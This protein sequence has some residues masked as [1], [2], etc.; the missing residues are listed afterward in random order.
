MTAISISSKP[1]AKIQL[2]AGREAYQ[3]IMERGLRPQ[4]VSLMIGASGGPKWLI[5]SRLDQ[6]L[7]EHFFSQAEQSIELVGSSIGAWR[8]ACYARSN[9]LEAIREFERLY[10]NQRYQRPFVQQDITDFIQ[11]VVDTLFGGDR[12]HEV[13][14][15]PNRHLHVIAARSR[16]FLNGK[17]KALQV[18]GLAMA[19]S[20]NVVSKRWVEWLYPK[21]MVSQDQRHGPYYSL[22]EQVALSENNL[23]EAL[24]A[25]GAIPLVMEPS[26]LTGGLDR[27]HW[28]GGMVDYH[29]S[30]P[31]KLEGG[32][33]LY[34]HFSPKLIPGW[35]DKG[36]SWRKVRSEHYQNVALLCPSESFIASLPFGKIPDRKD[37]TAMDDDTREK[38]WHQ[39][40]DQTNHLVD[41]FDRAWNLDGGRSLVRPIED[42]L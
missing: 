37:F 1:Q 33:A 20:G 21:V 4:D 31:F 26:K 2:F 23:S 29:F 7:C 11:G 16:R 6:Y 24:I 34:P 42:M 10:A 25:S 41:E 13:I 22:P 32:I 8:M 19:A 39:A 14:N 38:A 35:F 5:L 3:T 28:D 27:W 12:S 15:N 40:I 17:S 9:P 36:L 18:L 30:G